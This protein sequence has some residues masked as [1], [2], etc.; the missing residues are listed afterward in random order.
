M[1]GSEVEL[2]FQYLI[3]GKCNWF[4]GRVLDILLQSIW[5][6]RKRWFTI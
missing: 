6:P 3:K 2:Y 4:C 1:T 5:T